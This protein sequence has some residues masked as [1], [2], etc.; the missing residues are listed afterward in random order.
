VE[1][2]G[3]R[4]EGGGRRAEGGG[5]TCCSKAI[6]SCEGCSPP[7]ALQAAVTALAAPTICELDGPGCAVA[8]VAAAAAAAAASRSKSATMCCCAP[9]ALESVSKMHG[10]NVMRRRRPSSHDNVLGHEQDGQG[11]LGRGAREHTVESDGLLAGDVDNLAEVGGGREQLAVVPHVCN[12]LPERG[13]GGRDALGVDNAVLL[14]EL[15]HMP[16]DVLR[17]RVLRWAARRRARGWEHVVDGPDGIDDPAR[18][19]VVPAARRCGRH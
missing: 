13:G 17:G 11:Q 4:A 18:L 16:E 5:P 9:M 2:G 6:C 19:R 1:G 7:T 14:H 10:C 12:G 3:R 8:A 15:D